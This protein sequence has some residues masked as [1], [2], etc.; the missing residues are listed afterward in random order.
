[1]I[2]IDPET[3]RQPEG[4]AAGVNARPTIHRKWAPGK[5]TSAAKAKFPVLPAVCL[6]L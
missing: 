6:A 2:F 5:E 3:L 1:M 4:L